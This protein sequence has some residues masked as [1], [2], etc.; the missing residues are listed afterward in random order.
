MLATARPSSAPVGLVNDQ[1][2]LMMVGVGLDGEAVRRVSPTLKRFTGRAAYG[3][4]AFSAAFV[5]RGVRLELDVDGLRCRPAWAVITRIR[6]YGGEFVMAPAASPWTDTLQVV[7]FARR[8]PLALVRH[9]AAAA[10]GSMAHYQGAEI[11]EGRRVLVSGPE[12]AA[13][14][15]DGDPYVGPPLEIRTSAL[16]VHWIAPPPMSR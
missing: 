15:V 14:Q 13:V 9:V 16:S 11:L 5:D 12:G 8:G 6:R 2:F 4:A 10:T 7:T 3:V 1:V